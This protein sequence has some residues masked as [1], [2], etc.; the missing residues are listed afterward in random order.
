[1]TSCNAL[2]NKMNRLLPTSY[3][4]KSAN[5][6]L[7]KWNK[8]IGNHKQIRE[9]CNDIIGIRYIVHATEKELIQS[10]LKTVQNVNYNIDIVNFYEKPKAIDDGYRGIHLYFRNNPACFPVEI[11]LWTF[12]DA[13]LHFY[14]HEVIYKNK[15]SDEAITYSRTLRNILDSIPDAPKH[16]N[17]SFIHYLYKLVYETYGGD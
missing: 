17:P 13:I 2:K 3:R 1:M 16:I 10:V 9:V 6:F 7:N 5:S 8:N 15:Y 12:R 4:I 14:T 11:Q